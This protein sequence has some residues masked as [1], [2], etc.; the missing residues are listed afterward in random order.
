MTRSRSIKPRHRGHPRRAGKATLGGLVFSALTDAFLP[1]VAHADAPAATTNLVSRYDGNFSQAADQ[2]A[3]SPTLNG[4]GSMVAFESRALLTGEPTGGNLQV[5]LRNRATG[6][7]VLV[8]RADGP[9]GAVANASG[10]SPSISADGRYVVFES[11]ATNLVPG[12]TPVDRIACDNG[13]GEF[14][15]DV[16]IRDLV[17]NTTRL[18]SQRLRVD[19][20][21]RQSL[22]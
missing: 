15:G 9:N 5:F 10:V 11:S 3:A 7:T 12:F 18:V 17:N 4:D 20:H 16:Y 8:T 21:S 13:S 19:H 14:V 6:K 22:Q 1:A 2:G